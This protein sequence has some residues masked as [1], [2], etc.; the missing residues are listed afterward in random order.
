M[1][2]CKGYSHLNAL[3]F[4]YSVLQIQYITSG[5]A[6]WQMDTRGRRHET[7]IPLTPETASSAPPLVCTVVKHSKPSGDWFARWSVER[8]RTHYSLIGWE[9]ASWDQSRLFL[10]WILQWAGFQVIL[11]ADLLMCY[12]SLILGPLFGLFLPWVPTLA[13]SAN[14]VHY[15]AARSR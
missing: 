4:K 7:R 1:K 15:S 11:R 10:L 9:F 14:H 2:H 12:V 5:T 13:N 3:N 6:L 8:Q